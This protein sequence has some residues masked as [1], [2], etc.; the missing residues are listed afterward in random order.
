MTEEGIVARL[1]RCAASSCRPARRGRVGSS[2]SWEGD[3]P[4]AA[5]W[6][7]ISSAIYKRCFAA[8]V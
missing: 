7:A 1:A 5:P 8:A 2:S 3:E 6:V 4:S